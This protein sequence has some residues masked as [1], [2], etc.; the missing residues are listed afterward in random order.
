MDT[1]TIGKNL[2]YQRKLKG[3]SQEQ[4]SDKTQVTVRTIQRIEKDDVNPHLQTVKLLAAAL[5]IEVE[6][7]IVLE[8]PKEETIIK[9]WLLLLH[10]TPI[11]GLALPLCNILFPLFIWIHKREDNRIYNEHGI[12]VINFHIT[13]TLLFLVA[14]IC[15]LTIEGWG[16][17]LF[18]AVILF[19]LIV[20]IYNILKAL[21]NNTCSY[22]L[23]IPFFKLDKSKTAHRSAL[24]IL[25]LLSSTLGSQVAAQNIQRIDDTSISSEALTKRIQFLTE[26][27]KVSGIEVSIFNNSDIVYKEAFGFANIDTQEKLKTDHIIYGASF[28][29]AVFG[30]LIACLVDQNIFDLD[31]PLQEYFKVPIPK[32]DLEK[33]WREF[34]DLANDE[35]YKKITGRMCLSHSS[36]LQNWRWLNEDGE[37]DENGK[38]KIYFEPGTEYRYSGEGMM[39]L[40]YAIEEVTGKGLRELAQELVFSPL[41]MKNSSYL[42]EERFEGNF[43]LGHTTDQKTIAKDRSDETSAAGSM[44]TTLVDYSE[45]VSHILHLENENSPI[46][47]IMFE[48]NIKIKSKTQFGENST[49]K[50]DDNDDIQL[51]YGLGWGL[52]QSPYGFGAFKEGHGEGFQHYSIIF[53]KQG[54]GVVIMSNSDNAESIFKELLEVTIGDIYTPWE[55]EAYIPYDL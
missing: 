30:Y 6:E 27:A 47:K 28:S 36:G 21:K 16:F 48:P 41:N 18:I 15:L 7:L 29:K 25:L 54:I 3:Y 20:I 45:F 37:L 38:L 55:W 24:I 46:T 10:G 17:F 13:M 26:Q 44:S 35:R 11:L 8:N 34:G 39:L 42:W 4:L 9:K 14:F 33:E 22:P 23:S 50:T 49:V 2:S 19:T 53:P 31:K 5:D 12:K 32:I 1:T 40:Q 51:N 52:L 43:C